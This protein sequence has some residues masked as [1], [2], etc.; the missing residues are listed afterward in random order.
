MKE[1]GNF[2]RYVVRSFEDYL[3]VIKEVQGNES[4]IWYRGQSN[5][6]YQL[7]PSAM[8]KMVEVQD[9][10]GREIK[11]REV[12]E[13][14]NRGHIVTFIDVNAMLEEFKKEASKYLRIEPKNDFEWM[15]LAQ[16]YGIPTKLLDW[17]TDP[18]VALFFAM[19]EEG[20]ID[21][22]IDID[23]A[24]E[25]FDNYGYSELGAAVF[26]MNPIY[27]NSKTAEYKYKDENQL[28]EPV[29]VSENYE[30]FKEFIHPTEEKSFYLPH[31]ILGTDIDRRICRQS[32]NFTVH[33]INVWPLEQYDPIRSKMYKIFIPYTYINEIREKLNIMNINKDSIYG[34]SDLDLIS[35]KISNSEKD[36]FN[37]F[38][39]ELI[40]KYSK[41]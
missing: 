15:F 12:G 29:D 35:K 33:G 3:E 36:K 26:A 14:N 19:P 37:K 24:I 8:R 7:I 6:N 11:P 5:A 34:D 9:Q 4:E 1:D 21:I 25:E 16:H 18:L 39:Q 31:C 23:K 22:D 2:K 30:F 27:F 28:Y 20:E 17:S 40:E 32:G 13:F 38:I 10:F 41:I